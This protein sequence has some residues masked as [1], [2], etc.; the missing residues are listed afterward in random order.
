MHTVET[1]K[2]LRDKLMPDFVSYWEGVTI[3]TGSRQQWETA[4]KFYIK[5]MLLL[6]DSRYSDKHEI[7]RLVDGLNESAFYFS[8]EHLELIYEAA[9]KISDGKK[10]GSLIR[11]A[12]L[13]ASIK[14]IYSK[15]FDEGLSISVYHKF[16]YHYRFAGGQLNVITGIPSHGKSEFLDQLISLWAM[17]H[18]LKFAM[19]S[20]EN[21][22]KEFHIVKFLSKFTYKPF[23]SEGRMSSADL[24][25]AMKKIN[26]HLIFLEPHEDD[27]SLE[28]L[29][30]LVLDAKK[31][32]GISAFVLDPW[33]DIESNIPANKT[34]VQ[35]IGECL[36]KI[37]RFG[38]ANKITPFIVAHPTKLLPKQAG[39]PYP[40]PTAYNI[41]GGAMWF[42]KA[43]NILTVYRNP[44][45][46]ITVYVQ[47]IK[48]KQFGK[49][50]QIDFNYNPK[51]GV[52]E[53]K[54]EDI[55]QLPEGF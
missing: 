48:F 39:D 11:V 17:E 34:E 28:A 43:D 1:Y 20:P 36:T 9:Q 10:R 40:V 4:L 42:N 19:F 6:I 49:K 30:S 12:D 52:Y 55:N 51:T 45:D 27:I 3:E 22:P 23:Y 46:T 29:L 41:N 7:K 15:P 50:G 44:D 38:R 5:R 31:E 2:A 32:H 47:K 54:K 21:Y 18:K 13:E 33:N 37:R 53:E 25:G 26:E 35:Y 14:E 16:S 24:D 8:P